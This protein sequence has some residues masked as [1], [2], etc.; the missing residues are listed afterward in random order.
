MSETPPPFDRN[1]D[2]LSKNYL[3]PSCIADV[4][5]VIV[6]RAQWIDWIRTSRRR[7]RGRI[8]HSK[9]QPFL[10][11]VIA[12]IHQLNLSKRELV[13]CGCVW[14]GPP[15]ALA[16]KWPFV[17]EWCRTRGCN[18]GLWT[19]CT[20]GDWGVCRVT[21][22]SPLA[23]ALRWSWNCVDFRMR[24][25]SLNYNRWSGFETSPSISIQAV[26]VLLPLSFWRRVRVASNV[27][28]FWHRCLRNLPSLGWSNPAQSDSPD[29]RIRRRTR[30][31]RLL[32]TTH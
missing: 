7:W 15:L 2:L 30:W 8:V 25:I 26:K 13:L 12:I 21:S 23:R 24:N 17:W 5:D 11:S 16:W 20:E 31:G 14:L 27:L 32:P 10:I 28:A 3:R 9:S 6:E 18:K 29:P 1:G 19:I 22:T 4:V